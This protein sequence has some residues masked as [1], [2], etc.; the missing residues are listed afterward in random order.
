M[1][2]SCIEVI[3][4]VG[5]SLNAPWKSEL[6]QLPT[7]F[8]SQP[9][10]PQLLFLPSGSA[11]WGG[12]SCTCHGAGSAAVAAAVLVWL[13]A[14]GGPCAKGVPGGSGAGRIA[15][16][17][18]SLMFFF[19]LADSILTISY[20]ANGNSSLTL[21][22]RIFLTTSLTFPA[23]RLVGQAAGCRVPEQRQSGESCPYRAPAFVT[24]HCSQACSIQPRQL[25]A[26][27]DQRKNS[28]SRCAA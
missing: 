2:N 14:C 8:Q 16:M 23:G 26:V 3:E 12:G 10:P 15:T 19:Q 13:L 11:Y 4:T 6:L 25:C 22:H 1:A 7:S 17:T 18:Y 5:I 28:R 21:G 20:Y 24:D 27:A 9:W